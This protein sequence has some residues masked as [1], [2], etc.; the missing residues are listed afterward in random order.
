MKKLFLLLLVSVF[1]LST[2]FRKTEIYKLYST[3]TL[4]VEAKIESKYSEWVGKKIYTKVNV[5]VL[6]TY[7][8]SSPENIQFQMPGGRV[9]SQELIIDGNPTIKIGENA[10]LFLIYNKGRYSLHSMAMGYFNINEVNSEKIFFNKTIPKKFLVTHSSNKA[11]PD[12]PS[13]T[14][15]EFQN[16]AKDK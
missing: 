14:F 2:T 6:H 4:V 11:Y 15:N 16:V 3:S 10:L 5:S 8:G 13:F 1:A 12:K 9:G 7:K